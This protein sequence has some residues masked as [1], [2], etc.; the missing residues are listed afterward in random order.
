MMR[1]F[2][3]L[4]AS[5]M[6]CKQPLRLHE[7]S[8]A[9]A[10]LVNTKQSHEPARFFSAQPLALPQE[11]DTHSSEMEFPPTY[12]A[13]ENF[14]GQINT[15][16]VRVMSIQ[17]VKPSMPTPH[18]LRSYNLSAIDQIHAPSYVPFTFF[19]PNNVKDDTKIDEVILQRSKL[20]KQSMSETLA[21]FYPFAGKYTN[22]LH[23]ECNDEGVYYVET[24][25]DDYLSSFLAKP[26]YKLVRGLLPM[27]PNAPQGFYLVLIQVNFFN[28]GGVAISMSSSHKLIDGTTFMTFLKSWASTAKGDP[29]KFIYPNF[30]SPSLFPPN[31]TTPSYPSF[32]L[33]CL[34]IWPMM[35]SKGKCSTKRFRFDATALQ[36]LKAKA[37][38]SV[39]ATR[40]VAVTSLIWKCRLATPLPQNAIGNIIWNTVAR[41]EPN[42][43]LSLETM[44]GLINSSVAKID[45]TFV[46]QFK[47]EQGSDKVIDEIQWLGGQMSSYDADYYS[48]SS[49]CNSG[50]YEADFGWGRPA[51]TCFVYLNNDIPLHGNGILLMD[52]SS[53]DGIE[54][55]EREKL[56]EFY[57]RVSGTRI[58]ASF[59]RPDGM[60]QDMPLGLCRVIDSSTQQFA[61]RIEELE[62]LT[63]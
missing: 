3:T 2:G 13:G 59:I 38:E 52:T 56:L 26:D 62:C 28:C 61:S 15:S 57:E 50:M 9:A 17:N 25:V 6:A 58:H 55:W 34:A 63:N 23:I 7:R 47:G 4:L 54:V 14:V 11:Y 12:A 20:L 48:T 21:R 37:N 36:A 31:T 39:S 29:Q 45:T 27:P 43:N 18:N 24:Q 60:A 5:S 53:G 35:L 8:V 49:M 42:Q 44:A 1:R 40:V 33:S 30:D 22:D 46:E 41:C 10:Y 16:E 32:P 51:W 19:Y